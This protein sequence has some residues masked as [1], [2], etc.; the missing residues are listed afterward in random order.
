MLKLKAKAIVMG[1]MS[2]QRVKAMG[3]KR[4]KI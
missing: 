3:Q 4:K 1:T 2:E